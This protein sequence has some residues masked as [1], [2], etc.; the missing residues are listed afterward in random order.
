MKKVFVAILLGMVL[1]AGISSC[2]T[3][4]RCPAYSHAEQS[5]CELNS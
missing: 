2:K 5:S 3:H 4:E 1:A